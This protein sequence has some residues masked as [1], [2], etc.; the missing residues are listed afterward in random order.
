MLKEWF[1]I[2]KEGVNELFAVKKDRFNT[3]PIAKKSKKNLDNPNE[4]LTP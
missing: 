3:I 4:K 2:L 1:R